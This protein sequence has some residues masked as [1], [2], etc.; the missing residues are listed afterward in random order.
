MN[1][2]DLLNL[3]IGRDEALLRKK[4]ERPETELSVIKFLLNERK[5]EEIREIYE[6]CKNE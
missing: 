3:Y 6:D 5:E 4:A 1:E 2:T